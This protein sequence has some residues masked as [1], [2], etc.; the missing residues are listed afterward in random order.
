MICGALSG[1]YGALFGALIGFA[2]IGWFCSDWYKLPNDDFGL[3]IG[4]VG[5]VLF[6]G[7]CDLE[8]V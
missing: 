3:F 6:G 5:L 4:F 1:V 7:G 2:A 8:G